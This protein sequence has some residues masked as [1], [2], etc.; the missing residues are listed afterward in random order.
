M[1]TLY[2]EGVEGKYKWLTPK[3]AKKI[4]HSAGIQIDGGN[5]IVTPCKDIA[6]TGAKPSVVYSLFTDETGCKRITGLCFGIKDGKDYMF[7]YPTDGDNDKISLH[8]PLRPFPGFS[9]MPYEEREKIMPQPIT[10]DSSPEDLERW[11]EYNR[12]EERRHDAEFVEYL[13]TKKQ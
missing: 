2:K 4:R 1:A 9:L 3:Q 12:I 13:K 8:K 10:K 11:R 6:K 5:R 7:I